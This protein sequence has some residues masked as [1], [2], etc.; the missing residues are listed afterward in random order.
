MPQAVSC[1]AASP[2]VRALAMC[3]LAEGD[4][5]VGKLTPQEFMQ[6]FDPDCVLVA[7]TLLELQLQ[8]VA[9]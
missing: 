2:V 4:A 7:P 1:E 8:W 9:G 5:T 3:L 6:S